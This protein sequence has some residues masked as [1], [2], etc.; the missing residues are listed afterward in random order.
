MT[1]RKN[2]Y[3]S[4]YEGPNEISQDVIDREQMVLSVVKVSD[5]EGET[6]TRGSLYKFSMLN[7][8]EISHL[9]KTIMSLN[10]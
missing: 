9:G 4:G 6:V 8:T 7:N 5:P 10:W 3:I 2:C 1:L